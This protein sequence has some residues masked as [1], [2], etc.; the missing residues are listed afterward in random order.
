MIDGYRIELDDVS[1][2]YMKLEVGGI[3]IILLHCRCCLLDVKTFAISF[4]AFF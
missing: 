2:D 4:S 3:K 1:D